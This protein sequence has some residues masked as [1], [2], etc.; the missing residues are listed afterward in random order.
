MFIYIYI[1]MFIEAVPKDV[2]TDRGVN[3]MLM[4]ILNLKERGLLI[5][6]PPSCHWLPIS[7]AITGRTNQDISI[8]NLSSTS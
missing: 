4:D 1:Y 5:G 3:I 8:G 7:S 6:G 2:T